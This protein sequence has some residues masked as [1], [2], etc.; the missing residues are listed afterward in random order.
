MRFLN[1]QPPQETQE[2]EY[3]T[4]DKAVTV[5]NCFYYLSLLERFVETTKT[6]P[7]D[8]LKLYLV[9]AE[10]RYFKWAYASN[11]SFGST[12]NAVPPLG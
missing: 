7:E 4:F 10:Y 1:R 12:K 8:I 9:R 6:M 2:D 11:A 5:S 3:P